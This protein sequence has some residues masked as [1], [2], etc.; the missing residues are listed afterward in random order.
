MSKHSMRR[1]IDGSP[2]TDRSVSSASKCAA[3]VSLNRVR[4]DSSALRVASSTSDRLSPR[5][6]TRIF[7]RRSARAESQASSASTSSISNGRLISEGGTLHVVE[8]LHDRFA[9]R[10]RSPPSTAPGSVDSSTRSTT[11]PPRMANTW[12]TPPLGP[13][14]RPNTSRSPSWAVATFCWRSRR[15]CTVC[16]ESRSWA[17]SSK[18]SAPAASTMRSR[19]VLMSSSLRP[20]SRSLV[21]ATATP[22]CSSVQ[23]SRTQGAMQR[24]MS[25]SRHGRARVPVITS[26]HERMPNNRCESPIV[27]RAS[28]AGRNGP[29]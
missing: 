28:F 15:I 26:L 6:G 20:S 19:K 14:F 18:R 4:Y 12:I 2:I 17:A 25:Y 10:R 1:G 16:I 13:T 5:C 7:T 11:R 21:F 8:L 3:V 23:I 22:Y 24:L 29:A 9:A 27:R